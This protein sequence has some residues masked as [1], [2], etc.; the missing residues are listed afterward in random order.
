MVVVKLNS[1]DIA[2]RFPL[3]SFEE[4]Y[5]LGVPKTGAPTTNGG[6]IATEGGLVF[7]GATVD[8]KFRAFV[9]RTGKE[10]WVTNV[11]MD[12]TSLP[13]SWLCK[14]GKQYTGAFSA[15]G[16]HFTPD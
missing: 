6:S 11:G 2:W 9:S 14:N 10:L 12:V 3:G 13:I 5:K 16:S 1:G 4:L 7:V 8:G 15:G